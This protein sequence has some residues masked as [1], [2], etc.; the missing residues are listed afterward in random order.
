MN[1][2]LH[3]QLH[4]HIVLDCHIYNRSSEE[5]HKGDLYRQRD[6]CLVDKVGET[7]KKI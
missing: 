1:L 7:P 4:N 6:H 5:R 2:H 3:T